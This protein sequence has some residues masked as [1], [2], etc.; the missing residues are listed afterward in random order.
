M[1]SKELNSCEC[2][3]SQN[4]TRC[5]P[6]VDIFQSKHELKLTNLDFDSMYFVHRHT[7][8]YHPP[9]LATFLDWRSLMMEHVQSVIYMKLVGLHQPNVLACKSIFCDCEWQ[10]AAA[11]VCIKLS[12]SLKA[13]YSASVRPEWACNYDCNSV[14]KGLK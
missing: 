2:L 8:Y 4:C 13:D 1:V 14:S 11:Q 10:A 5:W 7:P 12:A 3:V 6:K 9:P